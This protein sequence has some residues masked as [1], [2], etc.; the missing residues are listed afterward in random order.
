MCR[1]INLESKTGKSLIIFYFQFQRSLDDV[2]GGASQS[3]RSSKRKTSMTAPIVDAFLRLTFLKVN[4]EKTTF[5][6]FGT[7]GCFFYYFPSL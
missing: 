7:L 2:D 5:Y 6:N 4:Q 3:P 1:W